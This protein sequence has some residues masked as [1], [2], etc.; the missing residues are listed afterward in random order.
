MAV[1]T[2]AAAPAVGDKIPVAFPLAFGS[3]STYTPALTA[4]TTSPTLGTGNVKQGRYFQVDNQVWV[5]V[6]IWVASTGFVT[7]SGT[8]EI[9]LPVAPVTTIR[10][11]FVGLIQLGG[12]NP[13]SYTARV[14]TGG[15]KVRFWR[16]DATAALAGGTLTANTT[17]EFSGWYEV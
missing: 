12:A 5:A 17:I 15:T 4:T 11:H 9:S 7:G 6:Q 14:E 8:Y 3:P 16:G 2:P 13:T 10:P 1:W